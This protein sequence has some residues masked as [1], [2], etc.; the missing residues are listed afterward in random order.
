MEDD[1]RER[2][3]RLENFLA[4]NFVRWEMRMERAEQRMERA[5]RRLDRL[6]RIV[7]VAIRAGS[8]Q[9]RELREA[10][11]RTEEHL[12][13]LAEAQRHTEERLDVLISVVDGI[14]RRL[15]PAAQ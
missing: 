7:T 8:R 4:D 5:E 10:Q 9:L 13:R 2:F 15:P 11:R 14:V 1:V 3:E 6:E 12:Q